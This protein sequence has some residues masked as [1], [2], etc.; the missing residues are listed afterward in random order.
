MQDECARQQA[1]LRWTGGAPIGR[2][3]PPRPP[4]GIEESPRGGGKG[5][6]GGLGGGVCARECARVSVQ[7]HK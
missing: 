3:L 7:G 5:G 4:Y 2:S 1:I 6:E